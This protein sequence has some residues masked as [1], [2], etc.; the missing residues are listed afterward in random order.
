MAIT[1]QTSLDSRNPNRATTNQTSLDSR[2]PNM[3]TINQTSL[4]SRNLNRAT[5]NQISLDSRN[6]NRATTNQTSLNLRNPNMKSR[7]ESPSRASPKRRTANPPVMRKIPRN[8]KVSA[9]ALEGR[10]LDSNGRVAPT[11]VARASVRS[12]PPIL[13]PP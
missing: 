5:T 1:N 3:T 6:P 7:S 13:A 11:L 12:L 9:Q 2:N 8:S 4:D 10:V